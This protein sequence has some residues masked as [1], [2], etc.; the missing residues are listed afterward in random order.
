MEH[1][2]QSL[3]NKKRLNKD[4]LGRLAGLVRKPLFK[5]LARNSKALF[6]KGKEKRKKSKSKSKKK[7]PS[8]YSGAK[9]TVKM[10]AIIMFQGICS[11]KRQIRVFAVTW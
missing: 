6:C 3:L 2:L 4:S 11:K 5:S 8:L 1:V 9:E 7:K 10:T